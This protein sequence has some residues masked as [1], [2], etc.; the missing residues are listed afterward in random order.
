M[1]YGRDLKQSS[2]FLGGAFTTRE[3]AQRAPQKP[4]GLPL[5]GPDQ[6]R[7][8]R[9]SPRRSFFWG[10]G[11]RESPFGPPMACQRVVSAAWGGEAAATDLKTAL[12]RFYFGGGA[13]VLQATGQAAQL[14]PPK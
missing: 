13:V 7:S 1:I 9:I 10:G 14:P 2:F 12:L 11:C 5:A 8:L 3:A 4:T 6:A